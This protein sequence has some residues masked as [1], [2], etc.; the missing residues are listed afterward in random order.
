MIG[1]HTCC[2]EACQSDLE[3]LVD[4][5]FVENYSLKVDILV[6]EV[7][8]LRSDVAVNMIVMRS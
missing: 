4:S 8:D 2:S 7:V 6:T 1:Y 5:L 3:G